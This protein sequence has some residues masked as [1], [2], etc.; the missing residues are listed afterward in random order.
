MPNPVV[1]ATIAQI[2]ASDNVIDSAIT[3]INGIAQMIADAVAAAIAGGATA[4]DL[5]PLS[6]LVTVLQT[7]SAALAAAVQANTPAP[8]PTPP[9]QAKIKASQAAK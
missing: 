3:L 5:Q 4:S 1:D 2:T 6:D 7:K 8:P 9:Q